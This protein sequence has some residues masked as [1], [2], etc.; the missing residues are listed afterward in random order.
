MQKIAS[1]RE[2][3]AELHRLLEQV[4][5]NPNRADLAQELRTLVARLDKTS[6]WWT[7]VLYRDNGNTF[8]LTVAGGNTPGGWSS[9][10]YVLGELKGRIKKAMDQTQTYLE[11]LG[12]QFRSAPHRVMGDDKKEKYVGWATYGLKPQDRDL[13]ADLKASPVR[14]YVR[15][16]GM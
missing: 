9:L 16:G 1:P 10:D 8:N 2:L 14:A 7:T 12:Y 11:G 3:Q 6:N 4:K 15:E 13:Q 5:K